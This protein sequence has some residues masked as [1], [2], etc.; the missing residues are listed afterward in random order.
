M[1]ISDAQRARHQQCLQEAEGYLELLTVFEEKW[2]LSYE[3]RKPLA[4]YV[5]KLLSHEDPH[6]V[7]L[8]KQLFL[9]GDAFRV[10]QRHDE[11]VG[12]LEQAVDLA[13]EDIHIWLMLG[14]C[15]KRCGK[16]D[17]AIA[18]LENALEFEPGEAVLWYNLACYWSL[19]DKAPK[20]AHFLSMAFDINP[21]YCE[22][23]G[24][25]SDFDPIRKHPAFLAVI[26]PEYERQE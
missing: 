3:C 15:Y 18:S 22:L 23:V 19:A 4:E 12:A 20:A 24:D 11:A 9:R 5:L 6:H 26:R 16:L 10:L 17:E 13:P 7:L 8:A 25:E 1:S 14:W 2:P 21:N